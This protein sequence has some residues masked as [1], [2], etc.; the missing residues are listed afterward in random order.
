MQY[1]TIIDIAKKLNISKSSVSRAFNNKY[2]IKKETRE[3]ILKTAK[4]MGYFPNPIAKK[5]CQKKT[6]NIGVII[7]EFIND[8][9]AEIIIGIQRILNP[10][11]YQV[12]LMQSDNNPDVELNNVKTLIQNMVDG[13]II[14]PCSDNG[15]M[16]YY[17]KELQKGCPIVFVNRIPESL[18]ATKIICDDEKLG[19]FATEHLIREGYA[20]IYMLSGPTNISVIRNRI[21][22]FKQAFRKHK[23]PKEQYQIIETGLLAHE[24]V[25]VVEDLIYKQDLPDAFFCSNDLVAMAAIKTLKKHNIKVPQ[26]IGVIGFSET[27]MARLYDP[28]LSSVRQPTYEMGE[29]AAEQLIRHLEDDKAEYKTIVLNGLLN[30][31]ESSTR[32]II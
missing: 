25:E 2:D 5:L 11:G 28:Q 22:G 32:T 4:E 20:K 18:N 26:D 14:A 7:P 31:R 30:I 27:Q 19:F 8:F 16:E 15:N 29:K 1:V 3:L 12:L 10:K 23:I 24:A 21:K 13:L 17:L 6:F 9:H